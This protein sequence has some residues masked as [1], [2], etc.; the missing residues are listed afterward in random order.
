M[1]SFID[2]F[3]VL[4]SDF[5]YLREKITSLES[6]I[7]E[8]EGK[9]MYV[10]NEGKMPM[11]SSSKNDLTQVKVNHHVES[12]IFS[13]QN[14]LN[15]K[16][17]NII[18]D[19]MWESTLSKAVL[20][21]RE[22]F[23][24]DYSREIFLRCSLEMVLEKDEQYRKMIGTL[25]GH[26][27]N[28]NVI[29][30]SSVFNSLCSV[31]MVIENSSNYD[32]KMWQ[33]LTEILLPIITDSHIKMLQLQRRAQAILKQEYYQEFINHLAKGLELIRRRKSVKDSSYDCGTYLRAS[34]VG[35]APVKGEIPFPV[36]DGIKDDLKGN[37]VNPVSR[38]DNNRNEKQ[39]L[40]GFGTFSEHKAAVQ[41]IETENCRAEVESLFNSLVIDENLGNAIQKIKKLQIIYDTNTI[42]EELINVGVQK[43]P[44]A[45]GTLLV[46]MMS[47]DL[48]NVK[49][50]LT[51]F[52]KHVN[53]VEKL[54][55]NPKTRANICGAFAEMLSPLMATKKTNVDQL[56]TVASS[57]LA[58]ETQTIFIWLV[59]K[60][61]NDIGVTTSSSM[62]QPS[63]MFKDKILKQ[64]QKYIEKGEQLENNDVVE[65]NVPKALKV[66]ALPLNV[67]NENMIDD[68]PEQHDEQ[69]KN[70]VSD[71][72]Q[73]ETYLMLKRKKL[74]KERIENMGDR[75]D[76]KIDNIID[77]T[78]KKVDNEAG[79]TQVK[80]DAPKL[81]LEQPPPKQP[82]N[83][84]S[85]AIKEKMEE[86]IEHLM[87]TG[88]MDECVTIIR[89]TFNE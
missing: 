14:G 83:L 32:T 25:F 85:S 54:I 57:M 18:E 33:N 20:Q 77:Q 16:T 47:C 10:R 21:V 80:L 68:R 6:R 26:L 35:R 69:D 38:N 44:V 39:I 46:K 51:I 65:S 52:C 58:E 9:M 89:D 60:K 7:K 4:K 17:R 37:A 50:I 1:T 86:I 56:A 23:K 31:L 27:L 61:L 22:T 64:F 62:T 79:D 76:I 71:P 81:E 84:P 48:V 40:C 24:D 36:D 63:N 70:Q 59:E 88:D 53:S 41:E 8:M 11:S 66:T 75:S 2:E 3:N 30:Q 42:I 72:S 87:S 28:Q 15:K 43:E 19:L 55:L 82:E 12:T 13:D 5:L 29:N 74:L 34:K 49:E 45:A 67:R 78:M 73:H